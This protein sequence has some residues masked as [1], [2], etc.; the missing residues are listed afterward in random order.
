MD[1]IEEAFHQSMETYS[2]MVNKQWVDIELFIQ[3]IRRRIRKTLNAVLKKVGSVKIQ[4]TL[5]V[6]LKKYI[7]DGEETKVRYVE[8]L[9]NSV[10]STLLHKEGIE[11]AIDEAVNDILNGF[12]HFNSS[13]S[14]WIIDSILQIFLRTYQYH[15]FEGRGT[16]HNGLPPYIKLKKA[17]I[18]IPC[19]DNKCFIYS[20]LA[21]L[22]KCKNPQKVSH[23]TKDKPCWKRINTKGL[24]YPVNIKQIPR[25]EK[26]N[27]SI[28]INVLTYHKTFFP[29]YTSQN[30]SF[31]TEHINLL[32]YRKHFYLIKNLSRLLFRDLPSKRHKWHICHFCL[33]RFKNDMQLEEHKRYCRKKMQKIEVPKKDTKISFN[34]YV[35][36]CKI[37][38]VLYWDTESILEQCPKEEIS[39]PQKTHKQQSHLPIS[40]CCF[41]KCIDDRFTTPPK[42]FT[43]EGCIDDFL[44]HLKSESLQIS[45]ILSQHIDVIKW[46]EQDEERFRN[47]KRCDMCHKRF[48]SYVKK[49]RDHYHIFSK[50]DNNGRYILCNRCNL[51]F[52]RQSTKIPVV[53]HCSE[54]YDLHHVIKHLRHVNHIDII[55][56]NSEKFICLTLRDLNIIFID[57][58]NFLPGSLRQLA[59]LYLENQKRYFKKKYLNFLTKDKTSQELLLGKGVFCYD[60]L[61]NTD[62]L[63]Y[64]QLPSQ[65]DFYDTLNKSP[66]TNIDYRRAQDV[67][68][69]MKCSSLQDYME[70]YMILDVLLLAA[71]CEQFR[72]TT[73]ESFQ[74]EAFH[75]V[76]SSSLTYQA[77]LKMTGITLD[78]VPDT[79]MYLFLQS[80]I[81]GGIAQTSHRYASANNE[82]CKDYDK[83]L[84]ESSILSSD[85]NA[86]Y[87]YCMRLPIPYKNFRWLT[88]EELSR[89]DIYTLQQTDPIGYII[90]CCLEYGTHLHDLH[91]QMPLCPESRKIDP[92]E[93][94]PYMKKLATTLGIKKV[95]S[96]PKLILTLNNKHRCV[97][98]Y[99]TLRFYLE[100]GLRLVKI[101]KAVSFRQKPW[102]KSY[103]DFN[104]M[105]RKAASNEFDVRL[106]K[107]YNNHIYGRLL[108]NVFKQ[109]KYKL[110]NNKSS[111]TK[112]VSKPTFKSAQYIRDDL[113][114][115]Q[116]SQPTIYCNSVI[117]AGTTI[118]ELS[119][120]LLYTFYHKF[121][122]KIYPADKEE[123]KLLY[124]DTDSYFLQVKD[125]NPHRHLEQNLHLFDRSNFPKNHRLYDDSRRRKPGLL[126]NNYGGEILM[127]CCALKPKMYAV[128]LSEN[129]QEAKAKGVSRTIIKSLTIDHYI[130]SLFMSKKTY[131]TSRSIRSYTHDLYTIEQ[132]KITLSPWCDKRYWLSDGIKS[133]AYGHYLLRG[134][135]RK[136]ENDS[137][138]YKRQKSCCDEE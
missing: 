34:K 79:D 1:L 17:C 18:S 28:S 94:S 20:I 59:D 54:K 91:N 23:Y 71:I 137:S 124:M 109:C 61:C 129:G 130:N 13:G 131:N 21:H 43:G 92:S 100:M 64:K 132:M 60:F 114:G 98:H 122:N 99:V 12:I 35:A 89:L 112:L 75:F 51:T 93:W 26:N 90:E 9:F 6:K 68:N 118:L 119:K 66:I 62:R 108:M 85:L 72:L 29:L 27:K 58:Y 86:L 81:K 80:S 67:W 88:Q 42:T 56:K 48:K 49:C 46:S 8:P 87:A 76:T 24:Q 120:V 105:K 14:G 102:L 115:V 32:L 96:G 37:P 97:L 15:G 101:H 16:Q 126:K 82:L 63:H 138:T 70:I 78:T 33:C 83:Q 123:N 65:A 10:V 19:T 50:K 110:V 116:S 7:Y 133:L 134:K 52:A 40:V 117:Y 95:T 106:Y 2:L 73:F 135:K 136:R 25:F 4:F 44:L 107:D 47:T 74:L 69:Q 39:P 113:V 104:T 57:S 77:M 121:F 111:F 55:P 3:H 11:K 45:S 125:P 128:K 22:I 30:T 38:F 5:K 36:M 127:E 31:A 84:E 41:R 103:I 53:A